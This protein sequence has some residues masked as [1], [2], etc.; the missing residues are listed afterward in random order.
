[1]NTFCYI[2]IINTNKGDFGLSVTKY[3]E[4]TENIIKGS[5]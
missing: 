5:G 4:K 2:C 1:M 3:H